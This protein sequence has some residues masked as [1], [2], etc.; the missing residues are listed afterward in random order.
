MFE[1][2]RKYQNDRKFLNLE[3]R[4]KNLL[5]LKKT[6]KENKADIL[7][8]LQLD[9][10]KN[11]NE[12]FLTEYLMVME[13]LNFLIKNFNKLAKPKKVRGSLFNFPSKTYLYKE[14]Y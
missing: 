14:P 2:M 8:A 4:R 6:I 1:E 9:L 5:A 7:K 13:E 12:G 3:K 11:P 10:D